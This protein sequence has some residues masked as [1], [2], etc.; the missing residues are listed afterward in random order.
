MLRRFLPLKAAY[1]VMRW[2]DI[3]SGSVSFWVCRHYPGLAKK[4]FRKAAER[5][6]PAD[7]DFDTHLAPLQPLGAA[8]LRA[9]R[10]RPV[11]G[12]ERRPR[13]D[14]HRPIET[15]TESG[16]KLTSGA[17]LDADVI[18]TATGFN[19]QYLGGIEVVVDGEE[20]DIASILT[21]KGMM[22]SGVPNLAF[23][24]GYTNASW[25]L[26]VELTCEFVCRLLNHM[27]AN[28]LDELRPASSTTPR[29]ARSRSSTSA[30]ATSSARSTGSRSRARE[31]PGGCIRTTSSTRG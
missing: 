9:A 12:D 14:R 15:F 17:E 11:R 8:P 30:P 23:A 7:F 18:V 22:A 13:R 16:L 1:A 20:V 25:T 21:Y 19:L 2:K 4:I 29:S 3:L 10:R 26:K 6:L 5:S 27:D 24:V 31:S 28:G